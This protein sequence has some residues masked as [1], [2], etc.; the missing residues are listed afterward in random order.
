MVGGTRSQAAV[1]AAAVQQQT[2]FG[3]DMAGICGGSS[4]A[5]LADHAAA[6]SPAVS[7]SRRSSGSLKREHPDEGDTEDNGSP[8][9]GQQ[10]GSSAV[11]GSIATLPDGRK[12]RAG[13]GG[14]GS[15]G[16][17]NLTPEQL[18][19]KRAND[20][21]AQRAIRER[22]RNEI[23]SLKRRIEELT[24][25]KPYQELQAAIKAKEAVEAENAEIKQR[26]AAV[27]GM[28]QPF[29][30]PGVAAGVQHGLSVVTD[31]HTTTHMYQHVP[32][33]GYMHSQGM[34]SVESPNHNSTPNGTASP[35]G[36][37]DISAGHMQQNP[38]IKHR[39]TQQQ[40]WQQ[41]MRSDFGTSDACRLLPVQDMN[42]AQDPTEP[43]QHQPPLQ[44]GQQTQLQQ[45]PQQQSRQNQHRHQQYPQQ[46]KSQQLQTGMIDPNLDPDLEP[47]LDSQ[48]HTSTPSGSNR[49]MNMPSGYSGRSNA[50]GK[51]EGHDGLVPNY[52]MPVKNCPRTC[53]LDGMLMDTLQERRQRAAEGLAP[54]EIT[55]PRYPS[56]SSLL[57]PSA[58]TDGRT[59]HPI[60]KVFTDIL[61]AFPQMTGEPERIAIHYIMSLLLRWQVNPTPEN[62]GYLPVWLR[63]LASQITLAH[64]VWLD[65]LPFPL[66][67]DKLVRGFA[68]A[69]AA[70]L[71]NY[72]LNDDAKG[73][74]V[75]GGSFKIRQPN[76]PCPGDDPAVPFDLFA[77]VYTDN[78]SL[79]WPHQNRS[80]LLES[81]GSGGELIITP[82]FESHLR[83]LDNWTLGPA[84]D[85]ALPHLRGSFNFK[86]ADGRV[87]L[88]GSS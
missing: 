77:G 20:R 82:A 37:V 34:M 1:A 51:A 74:D 31:S 47:R 57:N 33:S 39:Q 70:G 68:E 2:I 12:R 56:V 72:W 50:K 41:N 61:H 8:H 44:P 67:R 69:D 73:N 64:P 9:S 35:G 83:N 60:S 14:S 54:S 63:P 22:T 58:P 11:D 38:R 29:L 81:N 66:A 6:A 87:I 88:A 45:F 48:L 25:Q 71:A 59:L 17:A 18:A 21:E 32:S 52:S 53:P 76:N 16:V 13:G 79:N 28:L 40:Q 30:G 43:Q 3:S 15:R 75:V 80:S 78:I 36:S 85:F 7:T 27:I 4:L 24:N 65:Y 26:L 84:F 42:G 62:Y 46:L 55:G 86:A 23:D 5:G 10:R 19:K 49:S